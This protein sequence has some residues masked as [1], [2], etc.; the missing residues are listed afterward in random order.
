MGLVVEC[1]AATFRYLAVVSFPCKSAYKCL[2]A[3]LVGEFLWS[4]RLSKLQFL[5]QLCCNTKISLKASA[6]VKLVS[7]LTDP[8]VR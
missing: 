5:V 2:R 6:S 4:F 1:L 8:V 7:L 3:S